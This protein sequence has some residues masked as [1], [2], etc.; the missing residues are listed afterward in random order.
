MSRLRM[1]HATLPVAVGLLVVTGCG[2]EPV[3]GTPHE[4]TASTTAVPPAPTSEAD[5]P[6]GTG[7]PGGGYHYVEALC[8]RIDFSQVEAILPFSGEPLGNARND[9]PFASVNCINR[10]EAREGHAGGTTRVDVRWMP[11]PRLAAIEY[12]KT[13]PQ[14]SGGLDQVTELPGA[15]ERGVSRSGNGI[16][17]TA[18]SVLVQDSNLVVR[19][20]LAFSAIDAGDRAGPAVRSVASSVLALSG[21]DGP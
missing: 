11:T 1:I 18:A 6:G 14:F 19:V 4:V 7:A 3:T 10:S 2:T 17:D 21:S 20:E 12:E 16:N 9:G 13:L 15:W 5:A 8:D